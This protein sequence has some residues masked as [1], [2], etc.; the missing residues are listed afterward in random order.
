MMA[1]ESKQI[2]FRGRSTT[3]PMLHCIEHPQKKGSTARFELVS[4]PNKKDAEFLTDFFNDEVVVNLS[5]PKGKAK[6]RILSVIE[7]AD[8]IADYVHKNSDLNPDQ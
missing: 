4:I 6:F 8:E 5:S 1:T 3:H 2:I 7:S